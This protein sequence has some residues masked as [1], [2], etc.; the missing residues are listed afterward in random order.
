MHKLVVWSAFSRT[1][2]APRCIT[3]LDIVVCDPAES[4]N[5]ESMNVI[6]DPFDVGKCLTYQLAKVLFVQQRVFFTQCLEDFTI[7]LV[8]FIKADGAL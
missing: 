3:S 4:T 8:D 2:A 6:L 1:V 5:L 7:K